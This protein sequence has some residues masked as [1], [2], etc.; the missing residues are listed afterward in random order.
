VGM[1]A[2]PAVLTMLS[3]VSMCTELFH[4]LSPWRPLL[5]MGG[6]WGPQAMCEVNGGVCWQCGKKIFI[7]QK[8]VLTALPLHPPLT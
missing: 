6:G 7:A 8:Y 1:T 2:S 5:L 3:W 4:Y